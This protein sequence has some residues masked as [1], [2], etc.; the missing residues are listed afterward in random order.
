MKFLSIFIINQDYSKIVLPVVKNFSFV[1][2]PLSP[3]DAK[4][5]E[6]SSSALSAEWLFKGEN[7]AGDTVSVPDRPKDSVPKPAQNATLLFQAQ[8]NTKQPDICS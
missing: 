7:D 2:S 6:V 5:V 1:C 3:D 4:I 8:Q